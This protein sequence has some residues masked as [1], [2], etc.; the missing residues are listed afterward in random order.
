MSLDLTA[1]KIDLS[2]YSN[3]LLVDEHLLTEQTIINIDSVTMQPANT[4]NGGASN[5]TI[6]HESCILIGNSRWLFLCEF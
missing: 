4:Y 3:F 2:D 6:K 5:R 1:E